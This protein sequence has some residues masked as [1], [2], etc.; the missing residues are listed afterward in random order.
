MHRTIVRRSRHHNWLTIACFVVL[1]AVSAVGLAMWRM[2]SVEFMSVE[3]NSMAPIIR[4]GD[5]VMVRPVADPKSLVAGDVISYRSPADQSVIITHRIIRTEPRWRLLVTQGDN[6]SRADKPVSMDAVVGKVDA[7]V[8]YAGYVLDFI[9][10]PVG[11]ATAV[12]L[13]AAIILGSELTRLARHYTRPTYRLP[14][15]RHSH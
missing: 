12:Y 11:L 9:R 6:V 10:T 4:K 3:S 14:G 5:A 13:P 7:R 2:Q 8:A 15:Y 1:L